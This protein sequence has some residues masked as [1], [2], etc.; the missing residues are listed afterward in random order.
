MV[1]I[2]CST[3]SAV[4]VIVVIIFAIVKCRQKAKLMELEEEETRK[5]NEKRF[6]IQ[7][8]ED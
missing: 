7:Q 4:T 6:K 5:I 1:R 8:E 3:I 2:V